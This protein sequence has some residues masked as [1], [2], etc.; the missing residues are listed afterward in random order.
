LAIG[1]GHTFPNRK[2]AEVFEPLA[3]LNE[4]FSKLQDT[5]AAAMRH[6]ALL[7]GEQPR[8]FL[9][10]LVFFEKLGVVESTETWQRSRLIRNM[11]A[12]HYETSYDLIAE[13]F[14]ALAELSDMLL[15]TTK[16]LTACAERD[17]NIKPEPGDF[18][19]EFAR[20]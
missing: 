17:L 16:R 19:D 4:R 3:A 8:S 18:V 20:L 6:A 14:N 10:V 12:H 1:R 2:N 11:A 15:M 5:L 13:H 9:G 7:M